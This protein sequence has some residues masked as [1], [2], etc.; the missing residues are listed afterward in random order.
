[1]H[2][3]R[4]GLTR[5]GIEQRAIAAAAIRTAFEQESEGAPRAEW[6]ALADCP[7]ATLARLATLMGLIHRDCLTPSLLR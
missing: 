4:N 5:A 3:M 7:R 1:M 2:V 6:R